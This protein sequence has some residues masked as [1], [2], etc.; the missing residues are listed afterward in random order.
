VELRALAGGT[1]FHVLNSAGILTFPAH[2][3]DLVRPG[4]ILYGVSPLPEYSREI[5]PVLS[6]KS[7]VILLRDLPAGASV[8][9]GRSFIAEKPIRTALVAVGYA[10][11][12]PRQVSGRGA[13]VLVRGVR[14]PLLGRVTMDQIVVDVSMVPDAALGDE[15]TLIGSNGT[16]KIDVSELARQAD[17]ISWEILTGI[18]R[19]VEHFHT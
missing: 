9:Y 7:R 13:C 16:A 11:G 10:D 19:R 8:S 2:R 18:G 1:K 6:W 5:E 17:T 3:L 14:C 15:A 12:F 4:L